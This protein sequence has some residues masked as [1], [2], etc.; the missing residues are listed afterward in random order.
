VH[1]LDDAAWR[2]GGASRW[3]LHHSLAALAA[4][5]EA[6]GARLLLLRGEARQIIPRLAAAIGART[7][8][9]GRLYAPWARA[10][11]TAVAAAL[12]AEGRSLTLHTSSLLLEPDRLRTGQGKP[13]SIYTPFARAVMALGEP[14]PPLEAPARLAGVAPPEEGL[15][16]A[17]LALLPQRPEPDWAAEFAQLWS[18]GEAAAQARLEG[19]AAGTAAGYA[20][21][22][23][24]PGTDGTSRLS[25]R[26]HWGELS[27]RQ[28]WHAVGA[29]GR[30]GGRQT[31]LKEILWREFAYHT[32]WHRPELPDTPL[33]ARYD[34]FP[35]QP[36]GRLL[37]A[38]QRGRTG[39]PIVDAGMR[40]LWRFGWMHNRVRMVTSSLLVKHL[41]QPWQDGAA[42]FLDTLVDG[43]LASN[44]LN[45]QWVAGCGIDA[46][47]YFRVFNPVLQGSRFDP[48]GHY[49]R[50]FVPELAKLPD[51]WLHQPWAAPPEVLRAAGVVL[52]RTYPEPVVDLAGGRARALAA[53]AALRAGG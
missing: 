30:D 45:W 39:Y 11:D 9:A 53:L 8:H 29:G 41:L 24:I 51:R 32:L 27:P 17:A 10:R 14:A 7:V 44:S 40:Q 23:N 49:V 35:W 38:W 50:E 2:F 3:W 16:L 1:V 37:A 48:R 26:L 34:A 43:D 6:R 20:E 31:W 19:F 5:L 25:P 47:P 13:Y 21:G 46:T 4:A 18:P 12:E 52:G 42:W 28:V 36:D 22:R 15:P 33:R